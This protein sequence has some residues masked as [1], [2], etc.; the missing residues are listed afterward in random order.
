MNFHMAHMLEQSDY[1]LMKFKPSEQVRKYLR[2]AYSCTSEADIPDKIT[3]A[4]KNDF[5][6]AIELYE[7]LWL[8]PRLPKNI[9][10]HK[11]IEGCE[12]V[13]PEVKIPPRNPELERRI[14]KLKAMEEERKYRE[15]TKN[16]D[17]LRA[18]HPEDSI[19]YQ[20]KYN[21]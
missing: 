10:I 2:V 3:E 7:F 18:R 14:Q 11:L 5:K 16:V 12:I 13:L 21:Y 1:D 8:R 15:M 9:F 6:E 19:A 20:C 4:A 17:S